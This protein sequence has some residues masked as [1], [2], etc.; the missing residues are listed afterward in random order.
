MATTKT[1]AKIPLRI[2]L[3]MFF[4]F[5]DFNPGDHDRLFLNLELLVRNLGLILAR[6]CKE[7]INFRTRVS[8]G[9]KKLF[10]ALL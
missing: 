8:E 5:P 9:Y 3:N 6:Q 7:K 4:S 1:A 10:C 2:F